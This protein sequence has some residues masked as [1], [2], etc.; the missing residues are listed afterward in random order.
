MAPLLLL[1]LHG[2]NV[3]LAAF[4][5]ELAWK[6]ALAAHAVAWIMQFYGHGAH[7]GAE[8]VRTTAAALAS[9]VLPP[10][11]TLLL[12]LPCLRAPIFYP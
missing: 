12:L 7:E 4:G 2:A 3:F 10:S 8:C 1:A 11:L 6:L 9:S 5:P